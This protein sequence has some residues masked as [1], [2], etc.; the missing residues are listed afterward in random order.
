MMEGLKAVREDIEKLSEKA[1]R[2]GC[3]RLIAVS[4]TVDEKL[5]RQ[6]IAEGVVDIGENKPQELLKRI[7]AFNNSVNYHLIGHL[8]TNKVKKIVGLPVL[9]HSVDSIK[10]L[11]EIEKRSKEKDVVTEVL[12]ELNLAGED[13]KTG[14]PKSELEA[15]LKHMS[16]LDNV[17]LKGL[18]VMGPN[19][20]DKEEIRRVFREAFVLKR[21]I[22][23]KNYKNVEMAELS[24][25]MSNDYKIAI[26]EGSTMVRVGSVIY[27]K[28]TYNNDEK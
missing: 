5:V 22:S 9:I 15:F 16:L 27:G 13:T 6:S 28:R 21:E 24:M 14:L 20:E 18:M 19:V 26:E 1:G 4:K 23:E 12:C 7:E 17:R 2:K 25:G 10:L 3:V 11:D 8:Q